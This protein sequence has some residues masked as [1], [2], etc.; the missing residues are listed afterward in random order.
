MEGLIPFVRSLIPL[1]WTS[2]DVCPLLQSQGRFPCLSALSPAYNRFFRFIPGM[3]TVDLLAVIMAAKPFHSHSFIHC[4]YVQ[5]MVGLK[6]RIKSKT[7]KQEDFR[8]TGFVLPAATGVMHCLW[9]SNTQPPL[10]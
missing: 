6:S 2:C 7:N 8:V 9:V 4:M 10:V 5:T 1:F 3:A